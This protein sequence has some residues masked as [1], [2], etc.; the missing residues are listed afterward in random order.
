MKYQF[1][2]EK[3]HCS[4]CANLIKLVVGEI[5]SIQNFQLENIDFESQQATGSFE[6][7]NTLESLQAKLND[8]FTGDL[9]NYSF[10]NLVQV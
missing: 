1:E 9:A 3:I 5:E 2:I 8:A 4:G 10:K 7:V 6:S